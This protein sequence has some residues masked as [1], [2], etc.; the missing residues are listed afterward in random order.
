MGL[1]GQYAYGGINAHLSP[2][3]YY[4]G[5]FC[6]CLGVFQVISK[7]AR[8]VRLARLEPDDIDGILGYVLQDDLGGD[9][10]ERDTM[11]VT[12]ALGHAGG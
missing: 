2:Y 7:R 4:T 1:F 8:R 5:V 9:E 3:M 12:F 10:E 11:L 6:L